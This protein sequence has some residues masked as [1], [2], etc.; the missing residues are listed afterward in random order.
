MDVLKKIL[1]S[2]FFWVA[3]ALGLFALIFGLIRGGTEYEKVPTSEAVAVIM[4]TEPLK[5]VV[6]TDQEQLIQIT[7]ADGKKIRAYWVGSQQDSLAERLDQ[8]KADG[9]LEKWDGVNATP[10]FWSTLLTYLLPMLLIVGLFILIM[11]SAG[12]GAGDFAFHL[13]EDEE[14]PDISVSE[15]RDRGEAK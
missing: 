15:A 6:L 13:R 8:R 4:G 2:P 11:G 7:K 12:G 1:K 3:L 14:L 5:E 10:G 9:S